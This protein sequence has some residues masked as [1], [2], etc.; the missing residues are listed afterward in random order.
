MIRWMLLMV[1]S[2]A[3]VLGFALEVQSWTTQSGARVMYVRAPG[4]PMV[5]IRVMFDAGSSRD[6][7]QPGIARLYNNL[8]SEGAGD[9]DADTLARRLESQGIEISQ[10]TG[11]D[12]AWLSLRCLSEKSVLTLALDTLATMLANPRLD[13]DAIDRVRNQTLAEIAQTRQSAAQLGRL[14]LLRELYGDH[15]YAHDPKG[16]E[17]ALKGISY[18]DLLEFKQRY[19]V[20]ANA[21]IAVVGNI[22][23]AQAQMLAKRVVA[24]LPKGEKALPLPLPKPV[25]EHELR[26]RFPASQTHLLFAMPGISYQDEDFFP[27]LL[28]NHV[29]GGSGLTSILGEEVRNKRGLSYGISSDFSPLQSGGFWIMSAQ[30]K[31]AQAASTA[32]LMRRLLRQFIRNGPDDQQL[33]A[34]KKNLVGGFPLKLASNKKILQQISQMGFYDLPLNWLDVY[35]TRLEQITAQQVKAAFRKHMAMQKLI[36]LK[37][38]GDQDKK[39]GGAK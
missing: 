22:D 3:P 38:G 10:H 17:A 32:K 23:R 24:D 16:N 39:A 36:L 4:L 11:R 18:A 21:V 6:G 1:L 37:I 33:E 28:G 20:A 9:W 31:N 2:W 25:K 5:D 14:L 35:T 13:A 34:A 15:P 30:T 8:L 27:L 7:D 19:Y 29:F 12:M 26:H